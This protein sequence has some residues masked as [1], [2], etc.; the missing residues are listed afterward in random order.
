LEGAC[1]DWIWIVNC[2]AETKVDPLTML[3]GSTSV[4]RDVGVKPV[5]VNV[6]V[7]TPLFAGIELGDTEV[8]VGAAGFAVMVNVPA[9]EVEP[10]ETLFTTVTAMFAE[11]ASC[12][13]GTTALRFVLEFHVVAS[14]VPFHNTVADCKK[15]VPDTDSANAALPAATDEGLSWVIVGVGGD[16]EGLGLVPPPHAPRKSAARTSTVDGRAHVRTRLI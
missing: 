2:V 13:A 5:P 9:L 3:H 4:T 7:C 14:G 8:K 16:G 6:T 10:A 1:D 11:A 12:V 15:P